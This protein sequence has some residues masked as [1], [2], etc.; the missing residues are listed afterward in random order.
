MAHGLSLYIYPVL[1]LVPTV[2]PICPSINLL[3]FALVGVVYQ[4][5]K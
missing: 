2:I 5:P 1:L 3:L 4:Q